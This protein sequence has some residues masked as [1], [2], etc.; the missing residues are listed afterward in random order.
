MPGGDAQ[1]V[2]ITLSRLGFQ[3]ALCGIVGQDAFGQMVCGH[4]Q[5]AG[6]QL[7]AVYHSSKT[8]TA[9]TV[10]LIQPDGERHFLSRD[11][12]SY[13]LLEQLVTPL[14]PQTKVL[15][16]GSTFGLK[17]FDGAPA[18]R[19][20]KKAKACGVITVSDTGSNRRGMTL[21]DL[22]GYFPYLDYFVPSIYEVEALVGAHTPEK[23]ADA[24]IELGVGNVVIKLGKQ[25]CYIQNRQLKQYCPTYNVTPVDTT[26]A[27]DNFVAGMISGILRGKSFPESIDYANACGSLNTTQLGATGA[28]QSMGQVEAFM[29]RTKRLL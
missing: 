14:L 21:D 15:D 29:Q 24:L 26:G 2:S 11:L 6:V 18:V 13:G 28:I 17:D 8:N 27:G 3:V 19:V 10:C 22:T 4:T 16:I 5:S 7:E 9:R 20:L 12:D 1:N 25:G 23:I